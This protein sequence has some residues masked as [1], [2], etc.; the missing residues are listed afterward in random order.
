MTPLVI[1]VGTKRVVASLTTM[2]GTAGQAAGVQPVT[3]GN[4]ITVLAA[5]DSGRLVAR[6]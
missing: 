5:G 3:V 1:Q 2:V 4:G 6:M